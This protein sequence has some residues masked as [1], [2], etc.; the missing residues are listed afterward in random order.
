MKCGIEWKRMQKSGLQLDEFS[1]Y[2]F[3]TSTQIKTK[4]QNIIRATE[5]MT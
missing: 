5:R 3:V 4:P 1:V 2:S